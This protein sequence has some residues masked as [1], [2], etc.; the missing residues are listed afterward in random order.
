MKRYIGNVWSPGDQRSLQRFWEGVVVT[1]MAG[2]VR[3]G[4][5]KAGIL[6]GLQCLGEEGVLGQGFA[7]S[8]VRSAH[9]RNLLSLQI[10]I[11][12]VWDE[13]WGSAF[14]TSSQ[15]ILR[16]LL[17]LRFEKQGRRQMGG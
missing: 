11:Q 9:L 12:Y 15:A 17:P 5:E 1:W 13:A 10:L 16:L 14:L 7:N 8:N 6:E 3:I 2:D 4:G